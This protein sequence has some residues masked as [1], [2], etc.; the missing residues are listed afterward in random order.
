MCLW[1][2]FIWFFF[3]FFTFCMSFTQIR[4][5]LFGFIISKPW[6]IISIPCCAS[7]AFLCSSM[8]ARIA[9]SLRDVPLWGKDV[10]RL[11]SNS[12][13]RRTQFACCWEEDLK[14]IW[15]HLC[16]NVLSFWVS[17]RSLSLARNL[18][19]FSFSLGSHVT[20]APTIFEVAL[21]TQ[22]LTFCST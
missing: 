21:G 8:S 13:R 9:E 2:I 16:L 22:T 19:L 17:N 15:L 1:P 3:M 20:F 11:R 5:C 6:R 12:N 14:P 18:S 7:L 10:S 4:T